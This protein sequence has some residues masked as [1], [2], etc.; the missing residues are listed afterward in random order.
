MTHYN[1]ATIFLNC[2][3]LK[4]SKNYRKIIYFPMIVISKNKFLLLTLLLAIKDKLFRYMIC[5]YKLKNIYEILMT[6]W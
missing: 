1:V 6:P 3:I 2:F 4:S 5:I